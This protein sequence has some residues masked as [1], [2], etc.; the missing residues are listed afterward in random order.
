MLPA[1]AKLAKLA[2]P[3]RLR[4]TNPFAITYKNMKYLLFF[5]ALLIAIGAATY[6]Y[7]VSNPYLN[8]KPVS[9]NGQIAYMTIQSTAFSNNQQIPTKFTCDAENINPPLD[10][11]NIPFGAKSLVI[12]MED[13]DSPIKNFT[14]WIAFN[15]SSETTHL[16]ENFSSDNVAFGKNDFG[17][18]NYGGPCPQTGTH[19]YIF[20]LYAL[21]TILVLSRGATK[22]EVLENMKG[23]IM[24]QS[25]LTAIYKRQ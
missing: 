16:D 21:D 18:I 11:A 6:Y 24:E 15:I 13:P 3:R 10:F 23:H 8:H 7:F 5:I 17:N 9:K 12:I 2:Q 22:A 20:K 14:H 19:R 4:G 25:Q 1:E